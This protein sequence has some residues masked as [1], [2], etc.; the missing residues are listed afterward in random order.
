M[1]PTESWQGG[2]SASAPSG[3][4][5]PSAALLEDPRIVIA[6]EEYQTALDA[7]HEPDWREFLDRH[8]ELTP[9]LAEC[10]EGLAFVHQ[11][12]PRLQA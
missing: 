6:M 11:M 5:G 4:I 3:P 2:A 9:I 10:L 8:P 12:G 7:G 1:N